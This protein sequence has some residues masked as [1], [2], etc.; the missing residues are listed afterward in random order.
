[1]NSLE[2]GFSDILPVFANRMFEV[3]SPKFGLR[4]ANTKAFQSWR[5]SKDD[6]TLFRLT[7]KI[8]KILKFEE[9][10]HAKKFSN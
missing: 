6:R 9:N 7:A 3:L 10:F 2:V 4:T 5:T 1:M 8:L